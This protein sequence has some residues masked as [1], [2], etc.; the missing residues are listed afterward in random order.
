M[1]LMLEIH[2]NKNN[3][4]GEVGGPNVAFDLD[5]NK[6]IDVDTYKTSPR[7]NPRRKIIYEQT[8]LQKLTPRTKDAIYPYVLR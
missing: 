5:L 6:S 4:S 3:E 2:K 7:K 1:Q 8:L